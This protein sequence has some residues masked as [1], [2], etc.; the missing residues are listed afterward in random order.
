MRSFVQGLGLMPSPRF[1]ETTPLPSKAKAPRQNGELSVSLADK[2]QPVPVHEPS[3]EAK[4]AVAQ[5][6]LRALDLKR[7]LS[8]VDPSGGCLDYAAAVQKSG[9][10]DQILQAYLERSAGDVCRI[11]QDFFHDH[12]I[13]AEH[14][15]RFERWFKETY[16]AEPDQAGC[17]KRTNCGIGTQDS[18]E[19][20]ADLQITNGGFQ[21]P[22][23]EGLLE[24]VG[25]P[26]DSGS[27]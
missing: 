9:S 10:L 27:F 23:A 26:G 13:R 8:S 20:T 1:A 17:R 6:Y 2:K 3:T 19:A 5:E 25:G 11:K 15:F 22:S 24:E 18:S 4:S 14:R 21:K 16:D 7:W 12:N